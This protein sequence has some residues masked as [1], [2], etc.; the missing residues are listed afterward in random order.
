MLTK[1]IG[2]YIE[3]RLRL[4][5]AVLNVVEFQPKSFGI[6]GASA[7]MQHIQNGMKRN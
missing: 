5:S 7:M 4:S 6:S 3:H 2:K 1:D